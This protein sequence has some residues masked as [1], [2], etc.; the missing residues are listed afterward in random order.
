MKQIGMLNTEFLPDAVQWSEGMLL[1]P[2][3]FQ[4]NDIHLQALVHQ[5]LAAATPR[6]WG[7]RHL[8]VDAT[9]LA[10]GYVKITECDAVM[11]DGMPIVFRAFDDARS[12][13]IDVDAHCA[14]DGTPVPILLAIPPRAGALDVQATSIRRYE[15]V[16][17]RATLDETL[18]T[19]DVV[20]DRQ[21]VKLSLHVEDELPSGYPAV[22]LLEVRRNANGNIEFTPYHPPA[23]RLD[24]FAFLGESSL[25]RRLL[26][27]RDA[28]WDKLRQIVGLTT[29]DSPD[30]VAALGSEARSH[31]R[32]A[33]EIAACLPLADTVFADP[34]STPAD[35]WSALVQIVGRMTAIGSDPRPPA[36]DPYRHD[37]CQPQFHAALSFVDRKLALVRTRWDSMAFER[38]GEGAFSR[39]LPESAGGEILVELRPADGQT[40]TAMLSW[41]Q[42]ARIGSEDLLPVLR[43]RRLPGAE[44]RALGANEIASLGLRPEAMLFGLTPQTVSVAQGEV[45]TFRPGRSLVVQGE[46]G[47]GPAAIILH[48]HRDPADRAGNGDA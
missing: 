47:H 13:N 12:L 2:Q 43:Q 1:S 15:P 6:C 27:L 3:H 14:I 34:A 5:R 22:P 36:L 9:R 46:G 29:E 45:G 24:A 19:G 38:I 20:V 28:L 25:E 40:A 44:V 18:G 26:A 8:R 30:S 37:D 31:L 42:Q 11:P 32:V 7:V 16:A 39:R 35:A 10:K 33:R 4:Q 23:F 41:L 17:G 48:R 21:R